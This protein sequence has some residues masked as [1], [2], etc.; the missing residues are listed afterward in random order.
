MIDDNGKIAKLDGILD[1]FPTVMIGKTT[2]TTY[3][4]RGIP[5]PSWALVKTNITIK[6][7]DTFQ[8]I[9]GTERE[10]NLNLLLKIDV[11]ESIFFRFFH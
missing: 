11:S 1:Q 9:F 8:F 3:C 4:N 5:N 2:K 7:D 6:H 10:T